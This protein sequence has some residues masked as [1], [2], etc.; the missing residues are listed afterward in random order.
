MSLSPGYFVS[1]HVR[2]ARRYKRGG[3]GSVW[4]ADHLALQTQ[5]AV[6][7]MSEAMLEEPGAAARFAREA[8]SASQIKSP[9]VV[10]VHDH[11]ITSEGVPYM[12]MELLHGEDLAERM[13]RD[14]TVRLDEAAQIVT[15]VCRVLGRAHNLGIV[16]RDIK[17]SNIFLLETEGDV[18]VKV[19]DFGVA[20]LGDDGGKEL[21]AT[22]AMVG[23]LLYMSPEQLIRARSVDHRAD[24]WS[25]AVVMYRA[26]TG[27]RPF[28]SEDGLGS[29]CRVVE[30]AAFTPASKFVPG[31]PPAV[32]EWFERAFAPAI[33][34]RF[35]SAKEMAE[36]FH[37]AVGGESPISVKR[38]STVSGPDAGGT[39]TDTVLPWHG[40]GEDESHPVR[41]EPTGVEA[42]PQTLA[43][44]ASMPPPTARTKARRIAIGIVALVALSGLGGL[45][46]LRSLRGS[47]AAA[48]PTQALSKPEN[49]SS[50]PVNAALSVS[51]LPTPSTPAI[52]SSA[53]ASS[54]S[55][56]TASTP[57]PTTTVS[58]AP[59]APA[60][61][62][63]RY[64][65]PRPARPEKDY[66]F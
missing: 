64:G 45:V 35:G 55:A 56:V 44:T 49:P 27:Q 51:A 6:K 52:P 50:P 63:G 66:G 38:P 11:G 16:H 26:I 21:T 22:G 29:L 54:Q 59:P 33:E 65:G 37:N 53:S 3:M 42:P 58:A 60:K 30:Q 15:Q 20:K 34:D 47:S 46:A 23:T 43:G 14:G 7:F 2:L 9:H 13:K 39:L 32:D 57:A 4:I 31:L 8:T 36:A 5:V 48:A 19:L 1:Q 62:K 25:L 40:A 12:V 10:Q 17:P 28:N 41:S 18:F 24:L 61:G